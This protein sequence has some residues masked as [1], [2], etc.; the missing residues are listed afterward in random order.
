MG[1]GS[2]LCRGRRSGGDWCGWRHRRANVVSRRS[3]GQVGRAG[4]PESGSAAAQVAVPAHQ[5]L[6][7]LQVACYTPSDTYGTAH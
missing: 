2:W 6:S 1:A 4:G 7:G 3:G 5:V